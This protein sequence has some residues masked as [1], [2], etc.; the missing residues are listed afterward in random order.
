MQ[1]IEHLLQEH[2]DIMVQI[3]DLRAAT[4]DL[5][6][7]GDAALPDALP[8]LRRS[9][10]LTETQLAWH[11]R[12]EDEALFPALEAM[13]GAEASPTAVM[14]VEHA[15]IHTQA[16]LL[17]SLL[18]DGGA[19]ATLR[20]CAEELITLLDMHFEKEEQMLFP[21]IEQMLDADA[22]AEVGRKFEAVPQRTQS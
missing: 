10:L 1:P 9:A 20:A 11:A 4:R 21:M 14:R 5:A 22:L 17:R 7:R 3:A 8:T 12:K 13:L 16:G 2:R 19:A 15:S 18:A 6:A